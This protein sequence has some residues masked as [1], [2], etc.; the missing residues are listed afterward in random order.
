[1]WLII[2][3]ILDWSQNR[4]Y[5]SIYHLILLWKFISYFVSPSS[6]FYSIQ[7]YWILL[8]NTNWI[9]IIYPSDLTEPIFPT[10]TKQSII[11]SRNTM[12]ACHVIAQAEL[13]DYRCLQARNRTECLSRRN[14]SEQRRKSVRLARMRHVHRDLFAA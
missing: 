14:Y 2:F 6:Y 1:M 3:R 7:K 13:A 5:L 8:N 4:I 12:V 11:F 10:P 9:L